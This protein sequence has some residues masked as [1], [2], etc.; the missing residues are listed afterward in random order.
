M[1]TLY[2]H[3]PPQRPAHPLHP[4]ESIDRSLCALPPP[5]ETS[6]EE[7][8]ANLGMVRRV[9]TLGRGLGLLQGWDGHSEMTT[10]L[11]QVLHSAGLYIDW[12]KNDATMRRKR[13]RQ[14]TK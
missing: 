9:E 4:L 13:G 6:L 1:R 7:L 14:F 2:E 11:K 8:A 3:H 12:E 5:L 10:D